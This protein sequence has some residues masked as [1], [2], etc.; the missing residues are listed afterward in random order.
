M[1]ID[2]E[3]LEKHLLADEDLDE[4]ARLKQY[5]AA[6]PDE[7]MMVSNLK[8]KKRHWFTKWWGV[9]IIILFFFLVIFASMFFYYYKDFIKKI[10]AGTIH[11][12]VAY[13]NYDFA[14]RYDLLAISRDV[15]A[16]DPW[17]G[18]ENAK[19]VIVE[20]G[21]YSCSFCKDFNNKIMPQLMDK[22]YNDVLFIYRDFPVMSGAEGASVQ[23]ANVANCIYNHLNDPRDYW[24]VVHNYLFLMTDNL[25]SVHKDLDG[26]Y[27]VVK[28]EKCIND[29]MFYNEVLRDL[30]QGEE[31]GLRGTPSFFINGHPVAGSMEIEEWFYVIDKFLAANQ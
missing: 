3:E 30:N 13:M 14:T 23:I 29:K 21:D 2:R 19:V 6:L 8:Y 18:H 10:E 26:Y 24:R 28:A 16:D 25:G 1:P 27:D 17:W 22:Y 12:D 31:L 5:A 15:M 4:E 11:L 9:L 20:F 7:P